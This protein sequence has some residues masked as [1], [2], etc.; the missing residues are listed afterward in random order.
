MCD[1]TIISYIGKQNTAGRELQL[2]WNIKAAR[3]S[4]NHN[5]VILMHDGI[6]GSYIEKQTPSVQV[7]DTGNLI[8]MDKKRNLA[9]STTLHAR[10]P[11]WDALSPNGLHWE[12]GVVFHS[13][14]ELLLLIFCPLNKL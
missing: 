13:W 11:A 9:R 1:G 10:R 2:T 14:D 8:K 3:W 5:L 6:I 4:D 12:K 7:H